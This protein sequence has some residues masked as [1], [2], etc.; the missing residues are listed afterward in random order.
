MI[1]RAPPALNI[2]FF[3]V[4]RVD[5]RRIGMADIGCDIEAIEKIEWLLATLFFLS[6]KNWIPL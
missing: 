4:I 1:L 6:K 3:F 2:D 5:L